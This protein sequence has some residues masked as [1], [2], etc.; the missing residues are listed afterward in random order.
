MNAN[1]EYRQSKELKVKKK[2]IE[3]NAKNIAIWMNNSNKF[4]I[5]KILCFPNRHGIFLLGSNFLHKY[6]PMQIHQK[7]SS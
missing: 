5:P 1:E 4:I 2:K 7:F 6:L 3:Y